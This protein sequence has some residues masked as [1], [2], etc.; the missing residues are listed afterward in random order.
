MAQNAT[1]LTNDEAT[2]WLVALSPLN[3][4]PVTAAQVEA[5]PILSKNREIVCAAARALGAAP[6]SSH[7]WKTR[8]AASG[9]RSRG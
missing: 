5:D 6:T 1:G 9:F 4:D 7:I 8:M 3:G 2:G